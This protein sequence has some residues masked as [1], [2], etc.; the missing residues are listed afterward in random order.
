MELTAPVRRAKSR[1][2]TDWWGPNE[3]VLGPGYEA[4]TGRV[5]E[6]LGGVALDK[7]GLAWTITRSCAN[8]FS[9]LLT[10][11]HARLFDRMSEGEIDEV[12]QSFRFRNCRIR[13]GLRAV[14]EKHCKQEHGTP[15]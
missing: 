6:G 11:P 12:M 14:I 15:S 2:G 3:S 1:L 7:D 4:L 9:E 10:G 8:L 13:E 5:V